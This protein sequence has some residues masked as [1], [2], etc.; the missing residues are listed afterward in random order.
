MSVDVR[1]CAV[2]RHP[3]FAEIIEMLANGASA[4][5]IERAMRERG[6]PIKRETV[7]GHLDFC[8]ADGGDRQHAKAL[9]KIVKKADRGAPRAE[10][11]RDFAVAVQSKAL[12]D[13]AAGHLRVSAK[14]GLVAQG[15]IDK[16]EERAKDRA[17]VMDLARLLSGAGGMPPDELIDGEYVEIDEDGVPLLAPPELRDGD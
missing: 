7:K 6:K 15:L 12:K 13:L 3:Y 14:D 10:V 1:T 4:N 17:F 16:R 5:S 8:L 11:Q 9:D 2:E